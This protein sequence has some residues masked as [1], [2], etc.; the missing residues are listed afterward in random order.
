MLRTNILEGIKI[1]DASRI[2]TGPYCTQI[3]ADLGAEVIKIEPPK[4]D[5]TRYWGPPF[6]KKHLSSYY[7]TLN[8]NK[9]NITLN[10]KKPEDKKLFL[11]LVKWADVFVENY[12][13]GVTKKL[14]ITPEKLW[15]T[16]PTLVYLSIRGFGTKGPY[17]NRPAYDIIAQSET[18]IIA[19]TGT[20]NGEIAKTPVPIGDIAAALYGTIGILAAII[21][22]KKT[23]KG[24]H[25]QTSLFE[26]LL[27]WLTYQA[28]NAYL[29]NKNIKPTGTQHQNIAPY[30]AFQ[31]KDQ[32][33][34][35]I[36][37]GNE[38]Q[39]KKLCEALE[40]PELAT[41]P[42]YAT[43]QE[44]IK[45]RQALTKTL[46]NIFLQKTADEWENILTKHDIPFGKVREILEVLEHP[47]V[48]ALNNLF[49]LEF[50][51]ENKKIPL[52]KTPLSFSD[53]KPLPF[54]PPAPQDAHSEEIR[55]K[56]NK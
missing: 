31:C 14:E 44:R 49:W 24:I 50:P 47:Q 25:V 28:A 42:K 8:R 6:L 53:S 15:K 13:E 41:N 38:K 54:I 55:K 17:V 16:N 1:L 40:K 46:T 12:K 45:N 36:A 35:S 2:F 30:Q 9:K 18:G 21:Q 52:F 19:M 27:S 23:G 51:E 4:G 5:D 32:K 10:L 48:K 37:I 43:N 3:L 39:W 22:A 20:K 56:F 7:A 26:A 34:I 33:W 29:K 11:K